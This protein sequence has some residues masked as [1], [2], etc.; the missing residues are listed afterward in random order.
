MNH[1]FDELDNLFGAASGDLR[2]QL[3]EIDV[4]DFRPRNDGARAVAVAAVLL[5]AGFFGIPWLVDAFSDPTR[6][7]IGDVAETPDTGEGT[8]EGTG[9]TATAEIDLITGFDTTLAEVARERPAL[10][11]S[12]ADPAYG[13][14]VRRVTNFVDGSPRTELPASSVENADGSAILVFQDESAWAVVDRE[15]LEVTELARVARRSEPH[16]NPTEPD[17]IRHFAE[18]ST[19]RALML[20]ETSVDGSTQTLADLTDQVVERFPSAWF[21]SSGFGQAPSTGDVYAWAV[22][23]NA[24]D[25]LGFVTYDLTQDQIL[26]TIDAPT[27]DYG[28]FAATR[29]SPSGTFVIAGWV[30]NTISYNVN[31]EQ[32]TVLEQRDRQGAL[33]AMET[34]SDALITVDFTSEEPTGGHIYWIDLES[35]ERNLLYNLFDSANTSVEFAAASSRP[36]WAILTTHGCNNAGSWSC[37]KVMATHLET[38]TLVNLA[39]TY[40]CEESGVPEPHASLSPNFER[41]Y[42]NSNSQNCAQPVEVFELEIPANVFDLADS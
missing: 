11:E 15:T 31:L 37:E 38:G 4:P 40:R 29:I 19:E 22:F 32:A 10:G 33:V 13:A 14:S 39:H 5:V 7:E 20:L 3:D 27:E 28:E 18:S 12:V 17:L 1:D 23:D 42:F 6:I 36:G 35:G 25:L 16:W 9:E 8:S 30:G 2:S 26:G 24:G 21:L 41:L 34:G